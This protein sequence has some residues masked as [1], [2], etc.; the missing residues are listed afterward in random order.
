MG[1]ANAVLRAENEKRNKHPKGGITLRKASHK[2]RP[3]VSLPQVICRFFTPN[4]GLPK[5]KIVLRFCLS[6]I[7]YSKKA[8]NGAFFWKN[9]SRFLKNPCDFVAKIFKIRYNISYY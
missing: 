7:S 8:V 9:T 1:A 4:G 3:P 5:E 2:R 6:I